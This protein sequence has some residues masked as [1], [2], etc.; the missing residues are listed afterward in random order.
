VPRYFF[1]IQTSDGELKDD[2]HGTNLSNVA[3]GRSYAERTIKELR[4]ES[5]YDAP[6]LMMIVGTNSSDRFVITLRSSL[7][8]G[9]VR[10]RSRSRKTS[11]RFPSATV[12]AWLEVG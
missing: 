6:R 11:S 4:S 12:G 5:G 2:L 9:N 1:K 7:R 10:F 8:L 3:A